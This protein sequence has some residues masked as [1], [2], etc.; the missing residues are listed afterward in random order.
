MFLYQQK[1]DIQK[2]SPKELIE[3]DKVELNISLKS[4]LVISRQSVE[5]IIVIY[6]KLYNPNMQIRFLHFISF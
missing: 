2:P 1:L 6:Y 4:T 5:N 3:S